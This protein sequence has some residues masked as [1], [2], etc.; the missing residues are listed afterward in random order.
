MSTQLVLVPT[1]DQLSDIGQAMVKCGI[2]S[3][4]NSIWSR[5]GILLIRSALGT[6]EV[7]WQAI[8]KEAIFD[9]ANWRR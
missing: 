4:K 1:C 7:R 5:N 9:A 2:P 6:D 3:S 8:R